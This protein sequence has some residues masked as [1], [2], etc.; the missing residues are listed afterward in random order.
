MYEEVISGELK[1]VEAKEYEL[2]EAEANHDNMH[3][4][5]EVHDDVS[6]DDTE[7]ESFKYHSAL[8]I[9]FDDDSD[10][11][12]E[13]EEDEIDYL[14]DYEHKDDQEEKRKKGKEKWEEYKEEFKGSGNKIEDL[15][16]GWKSDDSSGVRKRKFLIFKLQKTCPITNGR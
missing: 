2:K 15:E 11:Y 4:I 10:E 7:D 9:A 3:G 16:S 6:Y 5:H 14:I 13:F 1:E 8:E 12:D